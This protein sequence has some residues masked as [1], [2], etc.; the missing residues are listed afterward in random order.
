MAHVEQ[1]HSK[2][3]KKKYFNGKFAQTAT[4]Y[5]FVFGKVDHFASISLKMKI[6]DVYIWAALNQAKKFNL[7]PRAIR[8]GK[9]KIAHWPHSVNGMT[10][11][12]LCTAACPSTRQQIQTITREQQ[13]QQRLKLNNKVAIKGHLALPAL[14]NT[15]SVLFSLAFFSF[16]SK[17]KLF[18]PTPT[19]AQ[20]TAGIAI[21]YAL[22]TGLVS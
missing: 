1:V 6:T 12:S 19:F 14:I 2:A 11:S 8:W 10:K 7:D 16:S 21:M 5:P 13:G 4:K 17:A 3:I 15:D 9:R 22:L 18:L 20:K